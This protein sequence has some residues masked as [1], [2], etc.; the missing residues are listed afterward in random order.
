MNQSRDMFMKINTTFVAEYELYGM[1]NPWAIRFQ[2][3]Q[4][5]TSTLTQQYVYAG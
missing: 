2:E 3:P 5:C 1:R 4:S